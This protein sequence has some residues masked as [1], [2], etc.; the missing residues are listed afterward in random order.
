MAPQTFDA[1]SSEEP[2]QMSTRKQFGA[3]E[4]V[5]KVSAAQNQTIPLNHPLAVEA[6][7]TKTP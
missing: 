5:T 3:R 2:Q 6:K 7:S 4:P 1:N